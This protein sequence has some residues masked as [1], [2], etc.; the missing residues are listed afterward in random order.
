ML[1]ANT[2]SRCRFRGAVRQ[3]GAFH[4]FIC[5]RFPPAPGATRENWARWP[6]VGDNDACGEFQPRAAAEKGEGQS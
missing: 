2:C 1:T 5:Y 6:W 4:A 3:P